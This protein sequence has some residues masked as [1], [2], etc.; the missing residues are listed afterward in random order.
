MRS[1]GCIG[2]ALHHGKS[3]QYNVRLISLR[4]RDWS[5]TT[6]LST[7]VSSLSFAIGTEI[8]SS[9]CISR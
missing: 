5:S 8:V 9:A 3:S 7:S 4:K 6:A 1:A 2:A